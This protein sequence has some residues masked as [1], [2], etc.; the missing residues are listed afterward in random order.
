[1]KHITIALL[2]LTLSACQTVYTTQPLP[3]P[4]RPELP[5]VQASEVE[6]LSD[7]AWKK[8]VLRDQALRSYTKE[9]EAVIQST[10]EGI[11]DE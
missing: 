8:I 9:L 5:T 11:E 1:M 2:A 4:P 10:W 7:D 3:M 6:C